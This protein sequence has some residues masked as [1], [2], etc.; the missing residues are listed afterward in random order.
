M[1]TS[2]VPAA[3]AALRSVKQ[4]AVSAAI[5]SPPQSGKSP[6][7]VISTTARGPICC[8]IGDAAHRWQSHTGLPPRGGMQSIRIL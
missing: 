3:G 5:L 4:T 7:A 2:N 8:I 1:P 6:Q